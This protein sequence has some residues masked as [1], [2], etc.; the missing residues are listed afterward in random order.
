MSRRAMS[1]SI[2]VREPTGVSESGG[3]AARPRRGRS[4]RPSLVQLNHLPTAARRAFQVLTATSALRG[5][6][7][8]AH[9][10]VGS[11][12]SERNRAA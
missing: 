11:E 4:V 9:L 1:Q 6:Q 3:W 12:W 8:V 5:F 10:E 7:R 2:V